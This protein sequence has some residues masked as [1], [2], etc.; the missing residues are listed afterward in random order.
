MPETL[1]PYRHVLL[2]PFILF[3]A[4]FMS[5]QLLSSAHAKEPV[6]LKEAVEVA[7]ISSHEIVAFKSS[8][9][10]QKEDIGIAKSN[11]FPKV[12]FEERYLRTNNPTYVFMS[13]LNQ[14]RFAMQDFAI[15]SLNDPS[16]ESD[17][18]TSIGI[19]QP[20]LARQANIGVD[21][22]ETAFSA[23]KE[24]Y[25]RKRE[26]TAMQVT[27]TYLMVQMAREFIQFLKMV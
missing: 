5:F 7:L 3:S 11:L 10:A 20:L 8:L 15:D 24:D 22:S 17:F 14:E 2:V 18:Q 27:K 12:T 4:F 21:M 23:K 1:K 19:F 13:K 16:P 9:S 26:E 6:S 25:Y